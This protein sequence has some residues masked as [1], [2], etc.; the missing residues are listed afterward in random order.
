MATERQRVKASTGPH[1][2]R[3]GS[4]SSLSSSTSKMRV[5]L[6]GMTPGWPVAPSS[7][8]CATPSSQPLMT[9]LRPIL[10]LKG[11]FRSL[12]ESNFFPFCSIPDAKEKREI[13]LAKVE[14]N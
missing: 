7:P 2:V 5:A 9:S 3:R 10:N 12:E 6:G 13:T 14:V 11:L 1:V 8:T 4:H